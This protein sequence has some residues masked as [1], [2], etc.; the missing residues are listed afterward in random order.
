MSL[1]NYNVSRDKFELDEKTQVMFAFPCNV[2]NYRFGT[3]RQEPCLHCDHNIGA[4]P[5]DEQ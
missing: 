2:C 3:D 1:E 4:E 5:D